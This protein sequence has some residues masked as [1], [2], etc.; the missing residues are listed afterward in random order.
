MNDLILAFGAAG[1][2]VATG[3]LLVAW[4]GRQLIIAR[5]ARSV[6]HEFDKKIEE[7]RSTLTQERAR[8]S[9]TTAAAL[10]VVTAAQA[11]ANTARID[12]ASGFGRRFW[13][14]ATATA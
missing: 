5:L 4:F 11:S 14:C 10:G 6:A 2:L 9:A 3:M 13:S 12:A 8:E 7:V 1:G